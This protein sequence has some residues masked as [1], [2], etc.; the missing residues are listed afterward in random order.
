[1]REVSAKGTPVIINSSDAAELEGLYD[2]VT[3]MSRGQVVET[4]T[5]DDV[6]AAR[7]VAAAVSA[8]THVDH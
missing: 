4:L 8:L 5:A 7:I 3:V 6:D 1:M 2:K